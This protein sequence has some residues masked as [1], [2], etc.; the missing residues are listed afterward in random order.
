MT[1]TMNIKEARVLFHSC[2][3]IYLGLE[4]ILSLEE[5]DYLESSN[6]GNM[7]ITDP[8]SCDLM[9]IDYALSR[10]VDHIVVIGH[11]DCR[12]MHTL[13]NEDLNAYSHIKL[14]HESIEEVKIAAVSEGFNPSSKE[15]LDRCARANIILQIAKIESLEQVKQG[16]IRISGWFYRS[17]RDFE[18]YDRES[19]KFISKKVTELLSC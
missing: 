2:G 13:F 11:A 1:K 3:D 18:I 5:N 15:G 16:N 12:A 19:N 14:L 17:D 6:L 10:G 9:T 4:N 8:G 7:I